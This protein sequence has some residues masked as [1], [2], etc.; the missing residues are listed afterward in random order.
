MSSS[1]YFTDNDR[2]RIASAVKEAEL[3]TSGEIVPVIVQSSS[4]YPES[5]FKALLAGMAIGLLIFEGYLLLLAGWNGG[6]WSSMVGAPLAAALGG[7]GGMMASMYI[8][9]IQRRFVGGSRMDTAVHDRAMKAF[10]EHEV[11]LTRDRTGIVLLVSLFEKRVEVFGDSTINEAVQSEDWSEVVAIV[12]RAIKN[13]KT[14]DGLVEGILK[15][16]S[17]LGGL[18]VSIR[19]DDTNELSNLPRFE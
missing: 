5:H 3:A 1:I 6:M 9:S 14:T 10:L 4:D 7:I 15:C 19:S 18:G 2:E 11:F 8:P 17:L 16:G 13:G 12:I